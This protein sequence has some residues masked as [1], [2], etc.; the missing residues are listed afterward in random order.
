[1]QFTLFRQEVLATSEKNKENST[2]LPR[3][4]ASNSSSMLFA[5]QII[6]LTRV[7]ATEYHRTANGSRW[8]PNG[9]IT[10]THQIELLVT[11]EQKVELV[12]RL[13]KQNRKSKQ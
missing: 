7:Y 8:G 3:T 13:V 9:T 12:D 11:V 10:A 4:P 2:D 6:Y 5:L 1:M